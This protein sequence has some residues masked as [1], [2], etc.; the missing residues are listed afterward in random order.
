MVR[1]YVNMFSDDLKEGFEKYNPLNEF[2]SIKE[3][4]KMNKGDE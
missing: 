4:I 2:T 1:E 3:K